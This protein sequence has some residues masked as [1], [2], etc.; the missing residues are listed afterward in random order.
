MGNSFTQPMHS[1]FVKK[2]YMIPKVAI[3][4]VARGRVLLCNKSTDQAIYKTLV[5]PRHKS[6]DCVELATINQIENESSLLW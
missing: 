4:H 1:Q 3:P 2:L 5:V 6:L